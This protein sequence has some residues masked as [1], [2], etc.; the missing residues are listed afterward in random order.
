M[1]S[2]SDP[3]CEADGVCLSD[4]LTFACEING[5]ISLRV[6][7]PNGHDETVSLGYG[8]EDVFLPDGFTAVTLSITEIDS[9]S[10]DFLLILSIANAS[11]LAGGEIRCDDT[12]DTNVAQAG[13]PILG[14]SCF[15]T[16]A[17]AYIYGHKAT[18]C[19]I[20]IVLVYIGIFTV[21]R[22][23]SLRV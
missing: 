2:F 17:I 13:C 22:N 23:I 3:R 1:A 16:R 6:G 4:P 19:N 5:A 12:F 21:P 11:L 14:K 10:R 9:S 8:P 18:W 7:L 20:M 15:Q